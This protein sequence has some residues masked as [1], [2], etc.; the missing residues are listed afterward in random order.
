MQGGRA[1]N[2]SLIKQ[3]ITAITSGGLSFYAVL[4]NYDKLEFCQELRRAIMKIKILF[5]G[6]LLSL[7]SSAYA[8]DTTE[9]VDTCSN[10][11]AQLSSIIQNNDANQVVF[12]TDKTWKNIDW[13]KSQLGQ[14]TQNTISKKTYFWKGFA[15]VTVNGMT[16][17]TIGAVPDALEKATPQEA[18]PTVDSAIK[19][20]GNPQKIKQHVF[21]RYSWICPQTNSNLIINTDEK[22]KVLN[23]AGMSCVAANNKGKNDSDCIGFTTAGN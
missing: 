20:L 21:L 2:F 16:V 19:V 10:A 6:V 8:A 15:L 22:G 9:T 4:S 14:G 3:D 5:C 18:N 17:S 23:M 13:I 7:V 11:I 1:I 12:A